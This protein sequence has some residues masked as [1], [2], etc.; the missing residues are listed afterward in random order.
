MLLS[1]SKSKILLL[2]HWSKI[3]RFLVFYVLSG[4]TDTYYH[5]SYL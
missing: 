1:F 4:G 2:S 5:L 3:L